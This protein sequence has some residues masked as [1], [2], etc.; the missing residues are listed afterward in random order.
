MVP[1]G[2]APEESAE[3]RKRFK[4]NM[5]VKINLHLSAI[6]MNAGKI[7]GT[8]VGTIVAVKNMFLP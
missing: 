1:K 4:R 6:N 7:Q 5:T 3:I 2:T 8:N